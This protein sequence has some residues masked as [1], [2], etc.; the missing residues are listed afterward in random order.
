MLIS[1][2]VIG[3]FTMLVF[4]EIL[5]WVFHLIMDFCQTQNWQAH[6]TGNRN[7]KTDCT[8]RCNGV[9][10]NDWL[11]ECCTDEK[12]CLVCGKLQSGSLFELKITWGERG[13]IDWCRLHSSQVHEHLH[14]WLIQ[15]TREL[16]RL[17]L[18]WSK[19][20]STI[21]YPSCSPVTP[22]SWIFVYTW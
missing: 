13:C 18:L 6:K 12:W 2:A 1:Y 3:V 16:V 22:G 8:T 15:I 19:S 5:Y 14:L 9:H 17:L 4:L 7:Q 21:G 10:T 11:T 20:S